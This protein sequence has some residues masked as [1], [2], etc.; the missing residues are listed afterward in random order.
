MLKFKNDIEK[1]KFRNTHNK[2]REYVFLDLEFNCFTDDLTF[3]EITSIGA[4][5]CDEDFKNISCFH[6]YVTPIS[7][8]K[9]KLNKENLDFY[10][11]N[12]KSIPKNG[13]NFIKTI[14]NFEKWLKNTDADIFVWGTTDTTVLYSNLEAT[15]TTNRFSYIV[16]KIKNIQPEIS[17]HITVLGNPIN[18][19]IS[20]EYM[21]KLFFF[22]SRV[23]HNGLLDAVDLM[24]VFKK[25]INKSE[26]NQDFL[27]E[28][29][30]LYRNV[31]TEF[32]FKNFK[33]NEKN[34]KNKR[35]TNNLSSK[36]TTNKT[37]EKI[38]KNSYSTLN[39]C[40]FNFTEEQPSFYLDKEDKN[41]LLFN[42]FENINND[43][44][45]DTIKN[46]CFFKITK[47][48]VVVYL[49]DKEYENKEIFSIPI[50]ILSNN[51]IT[52]LKNELFFSSI[53]DKNI[54]LKDFNT[55]V[56][57][58]LNYFLRSNNMNFSNNIKSISMLDNKLF[59]KRKTED[60]SNFIAKYNCYFTIKNEV[61][62]YTLA[63]NYKSIHNNKQKQ[64]FFNIPKTNKTKE[65]MTELIHLNKENKKIS[66]PKLIDIL[67]STKDIIKELINNKSLI[68]KRKGQVYMDNDRIVFFNGRHVEYIH[69][70][71][72]AFFIINENK[73]ILYI[74]NKQ[75]E[76]VY[77]FKVSKNKKSFYNINKLFKIYQKF[78]P[79]FTKIKNLNNKNMDLLNELKNLKEFTENNN[80]IY[81]VTN[82]SVVLRKIIKNNYYDE[83]Y[84]L[85]KVN[86]NIYFNKHYNISINFTDKT[87][88]KKILATCITSKIFKI[89]ELTT[90][91]QYLNKNYNNLFKIEYF[92]DELF[93]LLN[94]F[95]NSNKLKFSKNI[96]KLSIDYEYF[97]FKK[98]KTIKQIMM[99]L[100]TISTEILSSN[101]N[102][103]LKLFNNEYSFIYEVK[104]TEKNKEYFDELFRIIKKCKSNSWIK[105]LGI[106]KNIRNSIW[107]V[108]ENSNS[109]IN[110]S[111]SLDSNYLKT[112]KKKYL[113]HNTS[114]SIKKVNSNKL[115]LKIGSTNNMY[116]ISI[117][118]KNKVF[119][120]DLINNTLLYEESN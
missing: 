72:A 77:E 16:D 49:N 67:G 21:K 115:L 75:N 19:S 80:Y 120:D 15:N 119:V 5:K 66:S 10:K 117:N 9:V 24:K 18:Y 85:D 25:Y 52:K 71:N 104:N 105:V 94:S 47:N 38:I 39:K 2:K 33:F 44:N 88:C 83:I 106:N 82:S 70:D 8:E 28:L 3:H 53:I 109:E 42:K 12:N 6:S 48:N 34:K 61:K 99:P 62:N 107:R 74:K 112:D 114:M 36:I 100:D 90:L 64:E 31:D 35:T 108:V 46:D 13:K 96:L 27:Y 54:L 29:S 91:L 51:E 79:K 22:N 65:I 81:K 93:K 20:L 89:E 116:D 92:S 40:K 68:S 32:Q 58:V 56:C 76:K 118:E 97:K 57:T 69:L 84:P 14:E 41:K 101:E 59:I 86:V 11:I 63:F 37:N 26:I 23:M 78:K 45:F 73:P 30:Y 55:G 102:I 103:F 111:F 1:N 17:S 113:Y 43:T 87:N 98:E 4:L 110:T 60:N 7:Y 95:N 50:N